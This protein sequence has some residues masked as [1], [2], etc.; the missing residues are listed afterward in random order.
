MGLTISVLI[1]NF[2]TWAL[3]QKCVEELLRFS[4]EAIS[5]LLIVDDGSTEPMP[6]KFPEG[7]RIFAHT[8]N[9]GYVASVNIGFSNLGSDI[10]LILDSDAYPL[11][12]LVKPLAQE[13]EQDEQLG[14]VGLNL[15]D[16]FGKPTGSF[17][18]EPHAFGFI[19]GQQL[20]AS[21]NR[22]FSINKKRPICLYSCGMA[23]RRKAFEYIGGFDEN[24][25]FLDADIDFSMR[26]RKAHWKVEMGSGL[27]AFHKGGGSYQTH[28]KR[29]LRFHKN[30]WFLL[31]KHNYIT[32]AFLAKMLLAVR[33]FFEY[34]ILIFVGKII[35][36]DEM[37]EQKIASR[38]KL[39]GSVW[40]GYGNH[41]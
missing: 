32:S 3:T 2:N 35:T 1:T 28:A 29:I 5:E 41:V 37:L 30:R 39:L 11:T 24:F 33:H 21:L 26:L 40:S 34:F 38:K 6:E 13:F 8:P 17:Q 27:L 15:V 10:V 36:T 12:D 31:E 20:E 23:V 4:G 22:Q 19:I 9:K 16:E 7:V 18:H 14:A 25:D